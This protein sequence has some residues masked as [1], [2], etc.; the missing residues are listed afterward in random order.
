[1]SDLSDLREP[2]VP[3]IP[4]GPPRWLF[5][6]AVVVLLAGLTASFVGA[7]HIGVSWDETYH[8]QRLRNFL[9]RGWYLID[10]EMD[11]FHPG[12]WNSSTYVYGPVAALTLHWVNLLLGGETGG[13]VDAT[14]YAFTV[15]H[16]GT[17]VYG[18][19]GVLSTMGLARIVF[20]S[21]RWA[22]VTGAVLVAIPTWT[23]HSMFNIKDIPVAAGCTMVTLGVALVVVDRLLPGAFALMLLG[24]VIA[25]GTRP[26]IWSEI[27]LVFAVGLFGIARKQGAW[28]RIAVMVAAGLV[29]FLALALVYPHAFENPIHWMWQ[30][31]TQSADFQGKPGKRWYLPL[32]LIIELPN[33]VF[34][35]FVLGSWLLVKSFKTRERDRRVVLLLAFAQTVPLPVIAVVSASNVYTGLRQFLFCAPGVALV[36]TVAIVWLL[37]R[38][39][40]ARVVA[41]AT[42]VVPMVAQLALFPFDYAYSSAAATAIEPVAAKMDPRLQVRT[43]YWRTSVRELAGSVPA[44][45]FVVCTPIRRARGVFVRRANETAGDCA[46]DGIGPLQPYDDLRG[47][48]AELPPTKF[49]AVDTGYQRIGPNCTLLGSVTRRLYWRKIVLSTASRCAFL[50]ANY[51][52]KPVEFSG[53]GDGKSF[54]L[55]GWL[56]R[57]NQPGVLLTGSAGLVAFT[58]PDSWRA[59]P[60]EITGHLTPPAAGPL[61]VTVNGTQLPLV[62]ST[63]FRIPVPASV[64]DSYG[65]GRLLIDFTGAGMRLEDIALQP[66]ATSQ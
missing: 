34:G 39:V 18:L 66:A 29:S 62:S 33:L 50:P 17:A 49:Y 16:V 53:D 47:Q 3:V 65:A 63:Q 28:R 54:A 20:G 44:G 2:A 26:G 48:P 6:V 37:E 22:V 51:P 56:A 40:V 52:G 43:D 27:A 21:W 45:G 35:L 55:S 36:V 15:R 46:S 42:L 61:S 41:A 1:M 64:V 14:S 8:V 57:K 5:V 19:L 9:N 25:I 59:G 58:L 12:S 31:A 24:C 60:L 4:S 32:Y 11:G 7:F 10:S 38:R 23:G 13:H 30:S